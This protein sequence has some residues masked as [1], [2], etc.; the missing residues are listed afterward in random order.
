MRKQLIVVAV[1]VMALAL[2]LVAG[3]QDTGWTLR[4]RAV[5]LYPNSSSSTIVSADGKLDSGTRVRVNDK[6]A[7]EIDVAYKWSKYWGV[8]LSL[9]SARHQVDL[10]SGLFNG[11]QAG[12]VNIM[13][14]TATCQYYFQ[15][16][17]GFKPYVGL[18]LNW[19]QI[20]S[21]ETSSFFRAN[22]V[23]ADMDNSWGVTAQI[24]AD[25]MID[26]HWLV[27][28]DLK[29]SWMGTYTYIS[30]P[31]GHLPKVDTT[32]DPVIWGIGFGYRW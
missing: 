19:T 5:D 1:V 10:V 13:P 11:E 29:Y 31:S 2:P 9:T 12:S 15:T 18:G 8:E 21:F 20:S 28:F 3:A 24:G 6:W 22:G 14:L 26:K 30:D 16:S 27:N 4:L 17:T 25:V 23:S 7:P 32:I